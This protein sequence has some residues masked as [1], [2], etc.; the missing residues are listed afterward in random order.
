MARA[1]ATPDMN[2]HRMTDDLRFIDEDGQ[3]VAVSDWRGQPV[4]LVLLRWLG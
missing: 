3:Q 1:T 4:L 2:G